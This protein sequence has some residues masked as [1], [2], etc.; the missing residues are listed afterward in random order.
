M[1][2]LHT[3]AAVD[4]SAAFDAAVLAEQ[5][6]LLVHRRDDLPLNLLM[7]GIVSAILH[8]FY[9]RWLVS[10]WLGSF[11]LVIAIRYLTRRRYHTSAPS[12]DKARHWGRLFTLNAFAMA[13][14]WGLTGS[15]VLLAREPAYQVFVV[16]VLGGMMAGGIVSNSA[17]LPAMIAFLAPTITPLIVILI[18]R[19]DVMQIAMGLI[20]AL[21]TIV[22]VGTG[23]N[24]NKSIVENFRLRIRQDFLLIKLQ[25]SEAAMAEAQKIAHVGGL[26]LDIA[27]NK[28]IASAETWRIFGMDPA[29]FDLSVKA[30]ISRVHPDDRVA[31]EAIFAQFMRTGVSRDLDCRIVMDDGSIKHLHWSGRTTFDAEAHPVRL[32]STV[33][34]VTERT[35]SEATRRQLA[36]I[37]E[38]SG[39][40][41]IS[42]A[43]TGEITTW[44]RGAERL[45]GYP[46]EDMIGKNVRLI[47]PED[48]RVE[49]DHNLQ[50]LAHGQSIDP[51]DTERLRKDGVRIPVSIAV[52]P[53]RDAAGTISGASFIARD[54]SERKLAA[55]ALAYRERLLHAVTVGTGAL[56]KGEALS[57]GMAEALQVVGEALH[58]DRVV[59][60]RELPGE[61]ATTTVPAFR[62]IWEAPGIE[63]SIDPT[64]FPLTETDS[65]AIAVWHAPLIAN[66]PVMTDLATSEG[67]VH[68]LLDKLHIRSNL[69]A[70]IFVNDRLWGS[71]GIDACRET[72]TWTPSETDTLMTFGDIAG[73]V[74]THHE[75]RMA[76]EQS[77]GRFRALTA[78]AQDAI[79][80]VDS[81]ARIGTWNRAAERLLGFSAAEATGKPVQDILA[82]PRSGAEGDKSMA[83]FSTTGQGDAVGRTTQLMLLR[84]NGTEVAVELSLASAQ[85]ADGWEA[86]GI[87]R[88]ITERKTAEDKLAFANLLLKTQLEASLDGIVIVDQSKRVISFN[89]RFA[90]IWEIPPADLVSGSDD[91]VLAKVAA[92]VKDCQAFLARV[93]H[94]YEHPGEDSQDEFETIDGRFIDRYTVTLYGPT[95]AYLGRAWF[96]RD[97]TERKRVEAQALRMARYDVLT[98]LANR[99]V[100]VEALQHATAAA[101]RGEKSFAVLYLDLDHFKDV[102]DTLGHPVGDQ[103]L[104]LV[105]DRLR[106]NTRDTD[107]VARFGGDEFAIVVADIRDPADAAILADK[108]LKGF[109]APFVVQGSEI[110]SGASIG[111]ATYGAEAPD[112]ETLLSHADVALYRA[113]SEG[114]GG[115]RFF[116]DAMD[117]DVQTRVTLGAELRAA[118][119]ADQL[120]LVYQPQVA[121]DSGRI[122]GVEALARWRHP[123]RGIVGPDVFIPIAERIGIIAKL[124]HWALWEACRQGKAW[125]DAGIAPIRIG[126]NVSALQFRA[127]VGLEADIAAALAETGLPPHLLEI[128]LTESVLMDA[129]REHSD[130]LQRIQ[131]TGIT[132]AIDDFGTGY[133]SLDYLNRYPSDRIKIAQNFVTKLETTP[134]DAAIIKATIGLA[135]ELG[136]SVIAEGVETQRQY[137]LL[138]GWGCD[139]VQ[140]FYFSR[141]LE[142]EAATAVLRTGRIPPG[143]PA[144]LKAVK[145]PRAEVIAP[146]A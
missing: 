97:I 80:T 62:Y 128:E 73:S 117:E 21:F 83:M 66:K 98:G 102:N 118:L 46:A 45:F 30:L 15:A 29:T 58:V 113:K 107:T 69:V 138:K 146:V 141:P 134:G 65:A 124:G 40:A 122:T 119:D 48:R 67:P 19:G 12:A 109:S 42:E 11:C 26:E 18:S 35:Q 145:P 71:L 14:L 8:P 135:R 130:L 72:R 116:T 111:I 7:A 86:I 81:A 77:E 49:I 140:G 131:K 91:V 112:A 24:I 144:S 82:P 142:V 129:S 87:V 2:G 54:I 88:D 56:I 123:T 50:A 36:S 17:Y 61:A 76:L 78:A 47:I 5:V 143:L 59:L 90:D 44:N 60:M 70:P 6:R 13:C 108:L 110:H 106:E 114:R 94:L 27:H 20:L 79:I 25:T 38:S 51:F 89:Q 125:L 64:N 31:I 139:E 43:V 136:I 93:Q 75:T 115:Y 39:D 120:F 16:F 100:F 53:N 32:F 55:S 22:L 74:I 9:P 28:V 23:R 99:A 104:K 84:K 33:Q 132:V 57:P 68:A 92:S 37:V 137:D 105:A 127:P 41:I 4:D 10:A 34:D 101:K 3:G 85:L 1:P 121:I 63:V 103:L 96:F 95:R 126:V 133:S 52:S